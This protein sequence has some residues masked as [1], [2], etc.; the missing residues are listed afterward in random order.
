MVYNNIRPSEEPML[1]AVNGCIH[2]IKPG[3]TKNV[4]LLVQPEL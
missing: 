1:N 2:K 4:P 3:K